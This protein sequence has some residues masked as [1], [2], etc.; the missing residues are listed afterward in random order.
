MMQ[1][2]IGISVQFKQL[3]ALAWHQLSLLAL[4]KLALASGPTLPGCTW[5]SQDLGVKL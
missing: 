2:Q 3:S 5:Q 4:V 1:K